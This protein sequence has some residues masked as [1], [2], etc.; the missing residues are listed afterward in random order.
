[1]MRM[2]PLFG[3][4]GVGLLLLAAAS[5]VALFSRAAFG[6]KAGS[7]SDAG[8]T[9]WGLFII[10]LVVGLWLVAYSNYP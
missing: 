1:M 6:F 3:M 9:L 5:A 10:G 8:G 2:K 7:S 4:V